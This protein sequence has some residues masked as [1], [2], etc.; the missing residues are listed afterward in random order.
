[1][2]EPSHTDT[3]FS[4][5]NFEQFFEQ[6]LCGFLIADPLGNVIKS[7]ARLTGWLGFTPDEIRGKR[8]SD[9]FTIGS[10]IY[11]ETHLWPLLRM[12]GFFDEVLV[13]LKKSDGEKLR[14]L[15]NALE[16]RNDE[17][18]PRLIHYTIC[19]ASD[20]LQYEQN[21]QQAKKN[22]EQELLTQ[23]E[24]VALREQ[25][26]AVLGHDLRNPLS[27]IKM[28]IDLMQGTLVQPKELAILATLKRSAGRMNELVSNI[29]DFARTRLGEGIVLKRQPVELEDMLTQVAEELRLAFPKRNLITAYNISEEISCDP[30]RLGQLVSNLLAN[31]LTHGFSDT[32][33]YL[34]AVSVNNV[35]EI[36]VIN[37]SDPIPES[38][39]SRLFAPFTREGSRP[40]QNGL[41]LGLYIAAEIARAHNATL[42]CTSNAEE[43]TFL[44]SM[45]LTL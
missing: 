43:T 45:P 41:G 42:T 17:N 22:A 16:C 3:I 34:K 38:L 8:F 11:Y 23:K 35:L 20:R 31:A 27:A 19:K 10:K 14:V 5:E 12:Q 25:L 32:P 18:K 13:E 37:N 15:V 29:M 21:L 6:S 39:Q 2:T 28:A 26:I 33:V 24:T 7:N 4:G 9:L 36:S 30:D 40:S 44:F 1:M